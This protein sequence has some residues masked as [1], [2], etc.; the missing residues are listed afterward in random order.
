MNFLLKNDKQLINTE[1]KNFEE[2]K[3]NEIFEEEK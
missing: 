3:E 2:E 1:N